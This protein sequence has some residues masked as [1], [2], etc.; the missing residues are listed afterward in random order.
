MN[1]FLAASYKRIIQ[2][3]A[4]KDQKF[5]LNLFALGLVQATN[6]IIPLITLP[7]LIRTIGLENFGAV[8]YA[9]TIMAYIA[10]L[11]DY[12]FM[13]SATRQVAIY[14]SDVEKLSILFSTVTIARILLFLIS[15]LSIISLIL[16]VPR[17]QE[18]TLLYIYGLTFPL[19]LALMPTWFYQGLE[20]MRQITYLNIIAKLITIGLLFTIVISPSDFIYIL[21]IYGIANVASGT[22]GLFH[23][24]NRYGLVFKLPTFTKLVE[25]YK[26]GFNL[27]MTSVTAALVNNVN[28][29]ILAGF[30][31][32]HALGNYGMAEKI[33]FA[34]WQ[35]LAIFSTAIYPILC[36]L[37]QES[38]DM[39]RR[40]LIRTFVP[41]CGC[42]L[43]G[44]LIIFVWANDI[45]HLIADTVNQEAVTVL[46][47]MIFVPFIVCLNIPTYQTQL[48]NSITL[49]STRIYGYAAVLNVL[50]CLLL[51]SLWGAFGAALTMLIT[52]TAITIA[53]YVITEVKFKQYSLF[54]W[55][56][57]ILSND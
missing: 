9:L 50:L 41:F 32:N 2:S 42:V 34:I 22:Y 45:I 24:I 30:V 36:R 3:V 10:I 39:L 52:Q 38:H 57:A 19:G 12:G 40:F 55:R 20:Q 11:I 14:H 35:V 53:L 43:I 15:L 1:V 27:F 47:I 17:F 28:L 13:M 6:F 56:S 16:F 49:E 37:S 29:L 18:S 7:Y 46:R 21:G 48:A 26:N 51:T 44:C 23:A 31:D 54:R 33:I 8:S 4:G 25:Q 5:Y